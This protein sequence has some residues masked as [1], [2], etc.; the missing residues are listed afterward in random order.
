MRQ[1][2]KRVALLQ[3]LREGWRSERQGWVLDD[4]LSDVVWNAV[5][6]ALRE[7]IV[8]AADARARAELGALLGRS[9]SR[10]LRITDYGR[11]V[12]VYALAPVAP[13]PAQREPAP[14]ERLVRLLPAQMETLRVFV[15]I[16]HKLSRPPVKGLAERVA[17]AQFSLADKRWLLTL[18]P[19]QIDSAAY[20]LSLRTTVFSC[21]EAN[22][23]SREYGVRYHPDSGTVRGLAWGVRD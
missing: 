13:V 9:V 12:L 5:R 21:A 4:E 10:A 22:R 19:E 16:G 3:E 14:G 17:A 20:A 15:G 1:S 7:G 11:D 8:E 6:T 18:T 23:F 2:E